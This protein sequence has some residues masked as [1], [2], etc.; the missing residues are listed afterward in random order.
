M[1]RGDHLRSSTNGPTT[2][3]LELP[4]VAQRR[5]RP[6]SCRVSPFA[7][8]MG[9][10]FASRPSS[11]LCPGIAAR[12]AASVNLSASLASR[13][14]SNES[15]G[16]QPPPDLSP[17]P[18][19]RRLGLERTSQHRSYLKVKT[20]DVGCEI[21]GGG[22]GGSAPPDRAMCQQRLPCNFPPLKKNDK[23]QRTQV[24]GRNFFRLTRRFRFALH[25][26]LS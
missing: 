7:S 18:P 4:E 26:L 13:G 10:P 20:L 5:V 19:P 17:P 14:S 21:G 1:E 23:R 16:S 8:A 12:F 11:S 15:S 25:S 24:K 3:S 9:P 22:G 2:V 6:N